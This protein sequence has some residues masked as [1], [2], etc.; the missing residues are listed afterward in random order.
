DQKELLDEFNMMF[1]PGKSF[2]SLALLRS[3]VV[4]YGQKYNIVMSTKNS[5]YRS[6][7]LWCK[8]G[9]VYRKGKR[10]ANQQ[11]DKKV[12]KQRKKATQ[13]T[14]CECFIKAK[15]VNGGGGEWIIERSFGEHNHV[16]PKNKTVY[17]AHRK[18]SEEIKNLILRLLDTGQKINNVLEYL[19]MIG[20]KNIIKK[21]IENLQQQYKR[22]NKKEEQQQQQ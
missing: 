16:I 3:H 14:N 20:I 13:R 7:H 9:G 2:P 17:S 5:N 6:I 8:H 22:K 19:H 1:Q 12:I 15:V 18:Q 4:A 10:R 11:D 21:D